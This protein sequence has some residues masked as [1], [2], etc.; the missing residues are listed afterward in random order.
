MLFDIK[1][2][3][4]KAE[5]HK[6][7]FGTIGQTF[8]CYQ[9]RLKPYQVAQEKIISTAAIVHAILWPSL[10]TLEFFMT[11]SLFFLKVKIRR[12]GDHTE[13]VSDDMSLCNIVKR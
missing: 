3:N 4:L 9:S 5:H 8:E 2:T 1:H 10:G 7:E 12:V 6:V 13:I 11:S